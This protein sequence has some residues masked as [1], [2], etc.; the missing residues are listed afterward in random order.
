[1]KISEQVAF[2]K[3]VKMVITRKKWGGEVCNSVI[4]VDCSLNYSHHKY[5][6]KH[7]LTHKRRHRRTQATKPVADTMSNQFLSF[8]N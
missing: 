5:N 7:K 2:R 3:Q 6:T 1:M 8:L 4:S